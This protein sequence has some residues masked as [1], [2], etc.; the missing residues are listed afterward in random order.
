[1]LPIPGLIGDL[2]ELLKR[3]DTHGVDGCE[4]GIV[5]DQYGM[6]GPGSRCQTPSEAKH[7]CI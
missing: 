7:P 2:V 1:M 6:L 3:K 5:R 4:R